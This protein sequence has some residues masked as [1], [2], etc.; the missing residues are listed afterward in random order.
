M[1]QSLSCKADSRLAPQHIRNETVHYRVHKNTSTAPYPKPHK[2]S[3]RKFPQYPINS[4]LLG[5]KYS[6]QHPVLKHSQ[7]T[8]L[9]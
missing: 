9:P 8:F 4:S 3:L 1:D 5:A 7:S 6:P 2:S